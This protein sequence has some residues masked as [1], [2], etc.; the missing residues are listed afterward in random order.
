[1]IESSPKLAEIHDVTVA[2]SVTYNGMSTPQ[3][4]TGANASPNRT[5]TAVKNSRIVI[6]NIF[7]SSHYLDSLAFRRC[8][9]LLRAFA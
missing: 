3:L 5:A 4:T 7:Y 9:L 8:W 6:L 1:M 2:S